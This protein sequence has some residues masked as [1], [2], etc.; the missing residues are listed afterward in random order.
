[1]CKDFKFNGIMKGK[2]ELTTFSGSY[3]INIP[4]WWITK[5]LF[6]RKSNIKPKKEN[7]EVTFEA[8]ENKIIYVVTRSENATGKESSKKSKKAAAKKPKPK[9]EKSIE[10]LTKGMKT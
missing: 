10:D 4:I 7:F 6:R 3:Y 5:E 2:S 9:T 8:T 1:M